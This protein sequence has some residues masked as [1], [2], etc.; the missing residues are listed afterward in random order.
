LPS[1]SPSLVATK[2]P[3][4]KIRCFKNLHIIFY[5]SRIAKKRWGLLDA[6]I[7]FLNCERITFNLD[8]FK[9]I[10]NNPINQKIPELTCKNKRN[11]KEFFKKWLLILTFKR[12][13][14]FSFKFKMYCHPYHYHVFLPTHYQLDYH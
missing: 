10:I 5:Y 8:N 9:L 1:S 2:T 11:E 4:F 3:F 6:I 12:I 13:W 14:I 7:S